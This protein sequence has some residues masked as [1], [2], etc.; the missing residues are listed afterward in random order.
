MERRCKMA[1]CMIRNVVR[2]VLVCTALRFHGINW[3]KMVSTFN[4]DYFEI[5]SLHKKRNTSIQ[6]F[7]RRIQIL[8]YLL[9]M[10]MC[11]SK[12]V[13][14]QV[15]IFIKVRLFICKYRQIR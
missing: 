12:L 6:L 5:V 1:W 7:D 14:L 2:N 4:Q 10:R 11:L 13:P 8:V 3:V 9:F 15:E